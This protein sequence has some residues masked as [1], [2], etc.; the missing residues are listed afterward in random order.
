MAE[1]YCVFLG[2]AKAIAAL[3]EMHEKIIS[4]NHSEGVKL[5]PYTTHLHEV[6]CREY[7]ENPPGGY[8]NGSDNLCQVIAN[9]VSNASK[10]GKIA[11]IFEEH[12]GGWRDCESIVWD[13][14]EI[15]FGPSLEYKDQAVALGELPIEKDCLY[16]FTKYDNPD[17]WLSE[18]A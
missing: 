10:F 8:L 14:G 4:F 6:L 13:S 3:E 9:F 16:G 12:F 11:Y 18:R 5:V 1:T 2:E 7:K 17:S 15:V